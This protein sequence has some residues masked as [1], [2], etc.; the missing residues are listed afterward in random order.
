MSKMFS[1]WQG[2]EE[3]FSVEPLAPHGTV[4]VRRSVVL[5]STRNSEIVRPLGART[6][7]PP[8]MDIDDEMAESKWWHL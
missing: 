7:P 5:S 6:R 3:L 4:S 8:Q 2:S 1:S